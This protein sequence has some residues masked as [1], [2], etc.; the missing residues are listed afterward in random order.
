MNEKRVYLE[1][2][3]TLTI[4]IVAWRLQPQDLDLG[5]NIAHPQ[6]TGIGARQDGTPLLY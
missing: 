3:Y 5:R 4:L 2:G 1:T 6:K